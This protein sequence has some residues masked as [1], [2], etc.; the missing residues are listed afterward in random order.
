MKLISYI[1]IIVKVKLVYTR[2]V[3][4]DLSADPYEQKLYQMFT[5]YDVEAK[6]SL[7]KDS[8]S[9]LCKSLEL[10]DRESVLVSLLL[11]ESSNGR[12]TFKGFKEGLLNLLGTDE[13]EE[14]DD[15]EEDEDDGVNNDGEFFF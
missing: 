3:M 12:V 1:S 8:L 10:K 15:D 6:G 9:K 7:D 13:E 4:D 5:N 11:Q 2:F 14:D